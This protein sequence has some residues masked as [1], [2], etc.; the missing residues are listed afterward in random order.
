MQNIIHK[1]QPVEQAGFRKNFSTSDHLQAVNQIIE[2]FSEY[3]I[4]LHMAFI[5]FN[6][7][8]NSLKHSFMLSALRNQGIPESFIKII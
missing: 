8:F 1:Q 6:K 7:A 5:D 3:Q 2:K 4:N